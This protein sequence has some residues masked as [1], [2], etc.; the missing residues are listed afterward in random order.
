MGNEAEDIANVSEDSVL[1]NVSMIQMLDKMF[2]LSHVNSMYDV[3]RQYKLRVGG[4]SKLFPSS[5]DISSQIVQRKVSSSF[6][7]GCQDFHGP[8]FASGNKFPHCPHV[9]GHR[10]RR[11]RVEGS[12][13]RREGGGRRMKPEI[14]FSGLCLTCCQIESARSMVA[15][16]R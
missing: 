9:P 11:D 16:R 14:L 2:V 6:F 4:C 8:L 15:S 12:W 13:G 3:D 7:C 10:R 5:L 1:C